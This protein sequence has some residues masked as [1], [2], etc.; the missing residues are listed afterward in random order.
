MCFRV[1]HKMKHKGYA[2]ARMGLHG[3]TGTRGLRAVF[4][5]VC[6]F[7][8]TNV[9]PQ[10]AYIITVLLKRRWEG[11]NRMLVAVAHQKGSGMVPCHIHM[12]LTEELSH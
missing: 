9:Q 3:K 4:A 1:F 5:G 10:Y 12:D 6:A 2:G 7:M 11:P 8:R